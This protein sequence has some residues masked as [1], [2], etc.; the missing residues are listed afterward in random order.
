M[1]LAYC[2][3]IVPIVWFVRAVGSFVGPAAVRVARKPSPLFL[4]NS[5][6]RDNLR[7]SCPLKP[8]SPAGIPMAVGTERQRELR[9]L[10]TRKRKTKMILAKAQKAT[11]PEKQELARKLRRMTPGANVII[12]N[13]GLE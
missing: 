9:R 13:A 4:K 5:W 8:I 11:A 7:F 6:K 2:R 10:R 1:A 12:K 3:T